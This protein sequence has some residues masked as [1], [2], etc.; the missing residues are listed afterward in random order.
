MQM[1]KET[2]ELKHEDLYEKKN[3]ELGVVACV[4]YLSTCEAEVG[5]SRRVWAWLLQ[6][7]TLSQKQGKQT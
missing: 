1:K 5:G 7:K 4:C 6:S 2:C 3:P